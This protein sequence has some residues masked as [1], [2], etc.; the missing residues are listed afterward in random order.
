MPRRSTAIAKPGPA[1]ASADINRSTDFDSATTATQSYDVPGNSSDSQT[2]TSSSSYS[3]S[4]FDSAELAASAAPW[5]NPASNTQ[6][7]FVLYE[8]HDSE[9]VTSDWLGHSVRTDTDTDTAMSSGQWARS[10]HDDDQSDDV[11][12]V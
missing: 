9:E 8:E 4:D 5:L 3:T 7:H 12:E 10:N 1:A 6:S 11:P 2:I